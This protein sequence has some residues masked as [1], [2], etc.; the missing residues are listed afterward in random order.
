MVVRISDLVVACDSNDQGDVVRR[1]ILASLKN[2]DTVIL[3][4]S[5][6]SNVTSS[7]VNSAMIAL[8]PRYDVQAIKSRIHITRANRQ[9]GT[10]IKD[11]FMSIEKMRSVATGQDKSV[12]AARYAQVL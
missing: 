2:S 11:R 5:G 12:T 10:L 1:A 8:M 9:I 7:F 6:I 4:F 3:D